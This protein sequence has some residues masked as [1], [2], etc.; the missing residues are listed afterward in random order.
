[1]LLRNIPEG[2]PMRDVDIAWAAG[3]WDG[4]GSFVADS[5]SSVPSL[6]ISQSGDEAQAILV[7]FTL[8]LGVPGRIYEGWRKSDKHKPAYK[9]HIRG[10]YAARAFELCR[11]YLSL[12]KIEQAERHLTAWRSRQAAYVHP[13]SQRTHCPQGHE[14]TPENTRLNT[15]GARVCLACRRAQGMAAYYRNLEKSRAR[16]RADQR[17]Y[18]ERQ[19]AGVEIV[20]K[21]VEQTELNPQDRRS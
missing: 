19:A 1:M 4:E 13:M 12:T 2:E 5:R 15:N 6:Q 21:I 17:R 20:N 9:L 7:R 10:E 8:S 18:R 3:F 11:P 14:Y 16:S